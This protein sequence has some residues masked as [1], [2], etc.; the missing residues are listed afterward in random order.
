[1]K[2]TT[3]TIV[4]AVLGVAFSVGAYV[5]A[6]VTEPEP[7]ATFSK[8]GKPFYDDFDPADA[9]RLEL[10]AI[11]EGE[12]EPQT[13]RV[14]YTDGMWR[15]ES[16]HGYPAEAKDRLSKTAAAVIGLTRISLVGDRKDQYARFGVADPTSEDLADPAAAG[17][18]I[19]LLDKDDRVLADLIVGKRAE[20]NPAETSAEDD[21]AAKTKPLYYVRRPDEEQT[22][23]ARVELNVSTKFSDW[24]EPDLLKLD[25]NDVRDVLIDN[26][27][28][29]TGRLKLPDGQVIP[30]DVK[31]DRETLEL[32]RAEQW[33]DWKLEGLDDKTQSLD[34]AKIDAL[35]KVVDQMTLLGVAPRLKIEGQTPLTA[36]LQIKPPKS[37]KTMDA[38][39]A[40][41]QRLAQDLQ[42]KGFSIQ[43]DP[44]NMRT[45][46][47]KTLLE[48]KGAIPVE[49]LSENGDL[50]VATD[51]GVVYYLHFGSLVIGTEKEIQIGGKPKPKAEPKAAGKKS[52]AGKKKA[53]AE[54]AKDGDQDDTVRRYV[55]IRVEYDEKFYKDKPERPV[56]P[57]PPSRPVLV[58][59][60]PGP[61]QGR[62]RAPAVAQR[63]LP[64]GRRHPAV[65]KRPDPIAKFR[66]DLA[67][68]RSAKLQY[69]TDLANYKKKKQTFDEDVKKVK[70]RVRRLN[71]RFADW[72][73]V[74]STQNM[75][76]LTL[77]RKDLVKPK[78]AGDEKPPSKPP[79]QLP[80]R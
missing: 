44:K 22:Y 27:Q 46:R 75:K 72:Y 40:T 38:V 47:I 24:I 78:S 37:A 77:T 60:R 32:T 6:R 61:R 73:Y 63:P 7:V 53:A 34:S 4:Y 69:E 12:S 74:I 66:N 21:D 64:G 65:A 71:E 50:R 55:L 8:V 42:R 20:N 58:A 54:T 67:D 36:D 76:R 79:F 16:H 1:M 70:Q 29:A 51:K 57:V 56:K 14:A 3:R 15:I 11:P 52:N 25:A 68:Y 39:V 33:E 2:E 49:L 18:R 45:D 59:P 17:K 62:K 80:M 48:T 31:V 23:L 9:A 28:V 13:F 30:R 19:R 26:Y 10:T 41:F 43:L 35:L 5:V